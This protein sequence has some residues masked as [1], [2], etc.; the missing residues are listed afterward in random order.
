MT[1]DITADR[2]IIDAATA[3]PWEAD[4][5]ADTN[6]N[7]WRATGPH[8]DDLESGGQSEPGCIAEQ[9]ARR[10]ARL[11]A[12]ARQGWPAALDECERLRIALAVLSSAS[13]GFVRCENPRCLA[14][15]D[16]VLINSSEW[17]VNARGWWFCPVH[18]ES[19]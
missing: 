15:I 4:V 18:Q 11:I 16:R 8:H 2:A 9:A 17:N 3:G 7:G 12:A 14:S 5:W 1:I 13:N 19:L 10:D 6:S